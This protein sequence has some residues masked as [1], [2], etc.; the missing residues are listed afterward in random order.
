[1]FVVHL[2]G[3]LMASAQLILITHL[4]GSLLDSHFK[5]EESEGQ[6]IKRG[7]FRTTQILRDRARIYQILETRLFSTCSYAMP[8]VGDPY[9]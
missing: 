7:V 2:R 3:D 6:K 4:W 9:E 8:T 1:M 5:L